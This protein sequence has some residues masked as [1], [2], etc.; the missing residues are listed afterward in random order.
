VRVDA[1]SMDRIREKSLRIDVH[2]ANAVVW[3]PVRTRAPR[4]QKKRKKNETR[5]LAGPP[6]ARFGFG[7]RFASRTFFP[8]LPSDRTRSLEPL[9]TPGGTRSE[10]R[11]DRR[12]RLRVVVH[13]RRRCRGGVERRQWRRRKASRCARRDRNRGRDP[14]GGEKR[15]P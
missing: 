4:V 6:P 2:H 8:A 3:G 1:R 13:T 11:F 12:T 5:H 9:S 14:P 10:M 7:N 15:A